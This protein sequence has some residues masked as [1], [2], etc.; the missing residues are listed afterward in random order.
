VSISLFLF[1]AKAIVVY[2]MTEG[3]Q[4]AIGGAGSNALFFLRI[5]ESKKKK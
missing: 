1:L 5:S 3:V 4:E 2:Y